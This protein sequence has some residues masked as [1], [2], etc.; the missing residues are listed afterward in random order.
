MAQLKTSIH[1]YGASNTGVSG[2]VNLDPITYNPRYPG[3]D[4]TN[5]R[6]LE[7]KIDAL[8]LTGS[9]KEKAMDE[10]YRQILP[11]VQNEIKNSDRREYINQA[12]YE[13]SQIQDPEAKRMAQGK[14]TVTELAQKLKEKYNLD[15]SANDEDVFNSWINSLP[16]GGQ[17]LADYMN[18]GNRELLYQG[19]LETKQEVPEA[20][21]PTV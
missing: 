7:S 13:V 16:N 21:E 11:M 2:T 8:G 20:Q 10:A 5:Y 19:G 9:E 4:E 14:L 12:Q 18:D 1:N 6:K 3:F 17:L 15:P